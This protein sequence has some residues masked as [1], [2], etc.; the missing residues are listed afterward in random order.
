MTARERALSRNSQQ[1]T[2]E[3]EGARVVHVTVSGSTVNGDA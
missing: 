2:D 3:H 1:S